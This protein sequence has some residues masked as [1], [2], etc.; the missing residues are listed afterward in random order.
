MNSPP[1]VWSVSMANVAHQRQKPPTPEPATDTSTTG[2]FDGALRHLLHTL[3]YP[4]GVLPPDGMPRSPSPP[5]PSGFDWNLYEI[6]ENEGLEMSAEH[7]AVSEI[8]QALY[9]RFDEIS[10]IS[11]EE[12]RCERSEDGDEEEEV[13]EPISNDTTWGNTEPPRKRARMGDP[14]ATSREW[15]PWPDRIT[16]T[17]DIL[18]HLPRSVN[19]VDDVPSVKSMQE[20]NKRLQKM[21]GID[22]ICY[23]GALGH[24]YYVNSLE[25]IVSQEM[26][27]PKVR[28][29]LSFY[30]EDS[31]QRVSEARQATRWL[32][33]VPNDQLTPMARIGHQDYYIHKPA[34]LRDGQ[35]VMPV[36]WFMRQGL[37]YAKCWK[38]S[39][40]H[41]DSGSS[42]RVT[43]DDGFEVSQN[44][45]LKTFPE[46]EKDTPLYYSHIP[47]PSKISYI[48]N[49]I[50]HTRE[51]WTYT[52]PKSG[53]RWRALAQGSRV[54][55]FPIWLYCDDT[56]GNL[57]KKWNEHNSFLFT[58]AGLPRVKGLDPHH[59]T[60]VEILHV[61]LLGF[62]KYLWRDVIQNQLKNNQP[63]KD[64]L[65]TRL[66]SFN[67]AGRDFGAISQA[68]PF[69]L[70]DLVPA[71]CFSTWV[72]LSKL[73]PLIWQPSI[74][75]I[76][77]H[78]KLLESKIEHFLLC[79]AW[80][81]C[82]WFNKPKFHI[83]VHLPEHVRRFG[84]AILF[85]TE[86]FES[87]N[88]VIRAKSVHSNRHAPSHDISHAFAQGNRIRH[89]LS[90]G[91][92]A[93]KSFNGPNDMQASNFCRDSSMWIA[94]GF[95]V[96]SLVTSYTTVSQYRGL[97][98]KATRVTQGLCTSD[99]A[100]P[101]PL[102]QLLMGQ[103]AIVAASRYLSQA[104]LVSF[105][106]NKEIQLNNGD[107]CRLGDFVICE[108]KSDV[109]QPFIGRVSEIVQ[110]VGGPNDFNQLA[111]VILVQ[112]VL[113]G[114]AVVPYGMSRVEPCNEWLVFTP[115]ELVCTVNVQHD[116]A[117]SQC[118]PTG[119]QH[120]YQERH[121]TN[122]TRPV[123]M[124]TKNPD[125]LM[126]NTAQM[127]DAIH[128]QRFRIPAGGLS[129]EDI[130]KT[131]AEAELSS[132]KASPAVRGKGSRGRAAT[133]GAQS[134][135]GGRGGQQRPQPRHLA[136]LRG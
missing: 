29:H 107:T 2:L 49:P 30:P 124:H 52:D 47:V 42:W 96:K 36:R 131:S 19:N 98:S 53:N 6:H 9:S 20:L 97:A 73:V 32:H 17:L 45:F 58:A 133:R 25:Q 57:S 128:V 125:S 69:V 81:T 13:P 66:S 46:L 119:V 5:R 51:R 56:S 112:R 109:P 135:R 55:A 54:A 27:N 26:G 126:L 68:A 59:D 118:G 130:L 7:Q 82:R 127:R 8:A 72:A 33:E 37:L 110:Q 15:Y 70:Y 79:A 21:C 87:F 4:S 16:C 39:T 18:M 102:S 88:A 116:C 129:S 134:T 35:V 64:L 43:I 95:G 62:V 40:I 12:E 104:E 91:L 108:T 48:F 106:T 11:D 28:P 83:F 34:M 76:D 71:D 77:E 111:D 85:A 14:E 74:K 123:I 61:V 50:T 121:R 3:S 10:N 103:K 84:P 136:A 78:L 120:V 24:R 90:G 1:L 113:L 117:S 94:I 100:P 44:E 122:T 41:S 31:G 80:W 63:K 93:V 115:A 60:P 65:A 101:R 105:K 92:F 86:A 38:M 75:S 132:R 89:L 67:V 22:S 23:N 99:K 114:Q